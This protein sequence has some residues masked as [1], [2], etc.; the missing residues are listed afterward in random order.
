MTP[1]LEGQ[2]AYGQPPLVRED[3]NSV[4][5]LEISNPSCGAELHACCKAPPP[6]SVACVSHLLSDLSNTPS[7]KDQPINNS[8]SENSKWGSAEL[9]VSLGTDKDQI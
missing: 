1:H 9:S 2:S 6:P 3:G 7:G 5:T 8:L 4:I